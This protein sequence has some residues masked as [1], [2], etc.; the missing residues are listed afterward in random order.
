MKSFD[1]LAKDV[2]GRG[3]SWSEMAKADIKYHQFRRFK[4]TKEYRVEIIERLCK[5]NFLKLC[6]YAMNLILRYPLRFADNKIRKEKN[7][8]FRFIMP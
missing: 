3:R 7:E 8:N 5:S 2:D 6:A 1:T 4:T